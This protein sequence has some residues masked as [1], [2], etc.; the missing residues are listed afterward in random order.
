MSFSEI[1]IKDGTI[2][3]QCGDLD[4]TITQVDVSLAWPSIA[5]TF[6]ATGQFVWHDEPLEASLTIGDFYAALIGDPAGLKVRAQ[7]PTR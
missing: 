1:H 2:A 6:A 5:K 3:D 7:R 4:E